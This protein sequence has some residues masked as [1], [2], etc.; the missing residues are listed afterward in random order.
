MSLSD[1]WRLLVRHWLLLLL[2]PL[3]LSV[4]T[5]YFARHLPQTYSSDT[6]IYT[7]IASGYSLTGNAAAD[8]SVTSNAFD[9]LVNIITSR[10]TKE[11]V[12]Y[13]LL[14]NHLWQTQQDPALLNVAPY[15]SLRDNFPAALRHRL[16]GSS[17]AA[18]LDS[19]HR[20]GRANNT[21]ELYNLLNSTNST[22]S[23][24]SLSKIA[25]SRIASSDLIRLEYETYNPELCQ[26][27]LSLFTQV[28]LAESKN[29][30]EGQ[31]NTVIA[32]YDKEVKEA[33][34]R[35]D[36][37]EAA[38]LS[39]N[40]DNNIINY[41]EQAKGV[42]M[43]KDALATELNQ[44]SQQYAG[45]FA[46]L[47]AIGQRMGGKQE[48][49]LNS[50]QLLAQRQKL[51]RVTS[52][53]TDQKFFNQTSESP[54]LAKT[55]Q[56]QDEADKLAQDMQSSVDKYYAHTNSV[57]GIPNKELANEWVQDMV[58]VESYR[59]KIGVLRQRMQS[60]DKEYQRMAPLGATL[61]KNEREI[62]LAQ[63]AYLDVLARLDASKST[64]QNTQLTSNL[65]IIDPPNLPLHPKTSKLL[66]LV[67]TS[68]VGGFVFAASL[69]LGLGLLDRSLK[70]PSVAAQRI[71]LPVAG[72]LLD[73]HKPTKLLAASQQRNLNQLVR[74]ILLQANTPPAPT[75]FV[76]GIFSVQ[77]QAAKTTLCQSLAQRCH[78][79]GVPT[80]VL[81][82][83]NDERDEQLEDEVPSLFYQAEM[84]AVQGWQIDQ[85][86]Q[87][88]I[89]KRMMT[90]SAPNV[91]L[92]FIEFPA[93]REEAVPVGVLRQLHLVFLTVPA[94][95]AWS[96][97]D[98]QT[99]ERL[100]AATSAPV[101]VVLAGVAP[102]HSEEAFA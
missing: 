24:A 38:N 69:V 55:K 98:N 42:A 59:A 97:A 81:Y 87:H 4:S 49:L 36:K 101:E 23:I 44:V 58:Q 65:K 94:N 66:L 41:D 2:V 35:L 79:M 20:Y 45:A 91:Q 39:I 100:R 72:M 51:G 74:H 96:P 71:G 54:S 15:E 92:I 75:P 73:A 28:F 10:S 62:E 31:T 50:N 1:V 53:L 83:G 26:Y 11:E 43:Q 61:K 9:N 14:A 102:H 32:Y 93:L 88:A 25:A 77:Q 16:T 90:H 7:G 60:F 68:G 29:L 33:K 17:E 6:T 57:E 89:P 27:T 64:Q 47:K 40:R 21:N 80:L 52:A 86:I 78:Q 22:Y 76:I 85:L 8:Y 19:V 37:A 48:A 13:Q 34:A 84:A 12:I 70:K 99:M 46:S 3:V 30:R 5:Y 18:T 56:L 95:R 63:K 82:P 67:L